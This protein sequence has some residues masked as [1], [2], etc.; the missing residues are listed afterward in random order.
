[1]KDILFWGPFLLVFIL[2]SVFVIYP[3]Y[4]DYTKK[5]EQKEIENS[6]EQATQ[7]PGFVK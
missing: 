1:M 4:E 5:L 3:A 6:L 7:P 2:V